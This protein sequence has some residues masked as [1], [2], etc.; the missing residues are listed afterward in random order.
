MWKCFACFLI[1]KQH[2]YKQQ[3]SQSLKVARILA[4]FK[5]NA[6]AQFS[7]LS[8]SNKITP[9]EPLPYL[10]KTLLKLTI[11]LFYSK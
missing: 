9:L 5:Q 3:K 4:T 2:F 10:T 7:V 6:E 11:A 1:C 8:W